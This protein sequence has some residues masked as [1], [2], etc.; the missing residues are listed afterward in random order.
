MPISH[1]LEDFTSHTQGPLVV[2]EDAFEESRLAAFENGYQAGW[3]DASAAHAAEQSHV[4]ADFAQNL[5][6]LSFTYQEAYGHVMNML[7]PLLTQMVETLLPHIAHETL[8]ARIVSEVTE[9]ARAQANPR[10]ELTMSPASRTRL[11][12]ILTDEMPAMMQI[13]DDE[14]LGDGQVFLRIGSDERRIDL[15]GV[16]SA[17]GSI[18]TDFT[19]KD[20]G[21]VRHG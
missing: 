2:S 14:S 7:K 16:L 5:Q 4:S 18:M 10:V 17:I 20:E 13:I 1:L 19:K 12:A 11:E 15:D 6:E 21:Q 3:D 8:G 9:M